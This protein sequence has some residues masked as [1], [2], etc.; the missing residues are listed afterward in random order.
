[1]LLRSLF[2]LSLGLLFFGCG[3]KSTATKDQK[4]PDTLPFLSQADIQSL[5]DVTEKVD[6]LFYKLPISV[7]QDDPP[8]AKNSVGY[9]APASPAITAQCPASGRIAWIADGKIVRE[10]DFH[11]GDGC[12]YFRFLENNAFVYENAIGTEGIQ[13]FTTIVNQVDPKQS[14]KQ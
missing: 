7:S 10:A 3:N 4:N 8:S 2:L 12:N 5:H 13:F 11:L 6:I 9:I 1:M 14:P